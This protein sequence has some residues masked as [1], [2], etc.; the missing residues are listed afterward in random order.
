MRRARQNL[1]PGHGYLTGRLQS[2]VTNR[3]VRV[4]GEL[5][6]GAV[7]AYGVKYGAYV[8]ELYY[9]FILDAFDEIRGN[10]IHIITGT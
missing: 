3:Q 1:Y 5:L 7:G 6:V 4:E 2:S 10:A 9:K 8:H